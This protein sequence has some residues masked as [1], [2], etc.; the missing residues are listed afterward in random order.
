MHIIP[1]GSKLPISWWFIALLFNFHQIYKIN[2][3]I[4]SIK[5]LVINNIV[6]NKIL[7]IIFLFTQDVDI[8]SCKNNRFNI[9]YS[10]LFRSYYYF[11]FK[12]KYLPIDLIFL[13]IN[14]FY[15]YIDFLYYNNKR[16]LWIQFS[17]LIVL[18]FQFCFCFFQIIC[19]YVV[20][21]IQ[22]FSEALRNSESYLN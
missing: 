18:L 3:F 13:K 7:K 1:I 2:F 21:N 4:I 22:K 12:K 9:K 10:K 15:T 16:Q 5:K 6:F 8:T 17:N 20:M 14:I 11:K 19:Q